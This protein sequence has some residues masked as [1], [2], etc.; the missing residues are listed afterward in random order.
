VGEP[1]IEYQLDTEKKVSWLDVP[2]FIFDDSMNI[3]SDICLKERPH[4]S[5]GCC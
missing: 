1:S 4:V 5:V 3:I 2:T